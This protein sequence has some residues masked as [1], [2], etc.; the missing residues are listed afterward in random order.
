VSAGDFKT[1]GH[2]GGVPALRLPLADQAARER[3]R[4]DLDSTLVVEAAAG[5]GKTTELVARLISLVRSGRARLDRILA[6]TFT[7]KAAGELK[8]R[9]RG[10]L[11]RARDRSEG[12]ERAHLGQALQHLEVAGI[13][14]IHSLCADLLREFP[15]EAG[16]DPQFEVAAGESE[17]RLFDAA[18]DSWFPRAIAERLP[19]VRRL[20]RRRARGFGDSGPREELR[21]AAR[22]LIQRRDFT[23]AWKRPPFDRAA[24]LQSALGAVRS[25]AELYPK[26]HNQEDWIARSL[27]DLHRFITELDRREALVGRDEDGLEAELRELVSPRHGHWRWSGGPRKFAE[28]IDKQR[29]IELRDAAKVAL[30]AFAQAA[31]ADLAALLREELRPLV[32]LYEE[33]KAKAGALDFLDLLL[34]ARDLVRDSR[35]VRTELQARFTHLLVDEFQDTDPVQAE[36][37]FLLAADDPDERQS[38]RAR[39][40]PGKLF[41]VGDP[42][43]SIYRFRRADIALYEGAKAQL[44]AGGASLVHLS[45]SFRGVPDLQEM[46]NAAFAPRMKGGPA[47]S[48]ADY[49]ALDRARSGARSRPAVIALP[50]PRLYGKGPRVAPREVESSY[51]DAVGAFVE[52]LVR[53]SGWTLPEKGAEVPIEPRHICLLFKR[54]ASFGRDLTAPYAQAL[55]SRGMA[56]VLVGG[57]SF[58]GRP[59]VLALRNALAAIEWP[60]DEL[61]VYAALRGPLF[62]LTDDQLLVWRGAHG[63]LHPLRPFD[64]ESLA[65]LPPAQREVADALALL[66]AL[67]RGRNRQ[68]IAQTLARLLDGV[69]AH[70]GVALGSA[71]E[72]A[73][74]NLLRAQDLARRF[75][76]AGATSFRSFV[77]RLA[78]DAKGSEGSGDAAEAAVYEE[79]AE[80]VRLMTVHKAKGLEFPVVILCDPAAPAAQQRPTRLLDASRGLFAATLA[81]C[82]PADLL[83]HKEE[84]LQR[85]RDEA[86]RLVYV[87]ATRAKD[88]LVAPIVGEGTLDSWLSPLADVLYPRAG[89]ER[90]PRE[91]PGCPP[92]GKESVLVKSDEGDPRAQ[93][94]SP[95]LHTPRAGA[96]SLVVW[97]PRALR[98][99]V[100][101]EGGIR[102]EGL[103]LDLG[104]ESAGALV[105]RAHEEWLGALAAARELGGKPLYEVATVTAKAL[106]AAEEGGALAQGMVAIERVA[107]RE[108]GRPSGARFG[109]LVHG[110]L[111]LVELRAA[112]EERAAHARALASSIGRSLGATREEIDASARAALAALDH[113]LMRRAASS[114]D[115]RREV[116]LFC[117][118]AGGEIL[119]GV[120]DLAFREEDATGAR[121][122]VVDFKTDAL[123]EAE[124]KYAAQLRLYASAIA[125]ASGEPATPVVFAV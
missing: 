5:T 15:L 44:L 42:K 47:R 39:V 24:M 51:A 33:R 10:E 80:G 113:P 26:A 4:H 75:E 98:L 45:V 29:A 117:V 72:Q 53:S 83:E 6:V 91:A 9:L 115:C 86:L 25:A 34:R 49:V 99:G 8:L 122:T 27:G 23:A 66:R 87:A 102:R 116:D 21:R 55:E 110:V 67:H 90:A 95:G 71:G 11:E 73:L 19:G 58:H 89:E 70:A 37:L 12:S 108:A 17:S 96:H 43:Q 16:I 121:W 65:A 32:V 41:V 100:E 123:P 84:L 64:D 106:E 107:A 97:D 81:G 2:I 88:I 61:H 93:S 85:D 31:D 63:R 3:I 68:P 82:L 94:I 125:A 1:T 14:T 50:A 57:R 13:G 36:L 112:S 92:F 74:A 101:P 104:A 54:F 46:V 48:Q 30:D 109:T 60:D 119:E 59:E 38:E 114:A 69:R 78:R 18:F 120:A 56:H 118:Q 79:G 7:D 20:L 124:P 28:G 103:L 40:V 76:A 111:A 62:A 35:S 22:D 105:S 77:Q 52:W